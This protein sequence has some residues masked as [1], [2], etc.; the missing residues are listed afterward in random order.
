VTGL[1]LLPLLAMLGCTDASEPVIDA[2]ADVATLAADGVLPAGA[3]ILDASALPD[4]LG[5]CSRGTPTPGT[6]AFRPLPADIARLE[7]AVPAAVRAA[8]PAQ[9]GSH[10]AFPTGWVRQYVGIERGNQRSVYG[11]FVP[12]HAARYGGALDRQPM[13]VCDGGAAFFGVEF[14][15]GNGTVTHIAFNGHA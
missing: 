11:N 15:L 12:G 3:Y 7:A 8:R 2:G 6:G 13:V 14:D 10:D 5:Q 9:L 1:R 4:M